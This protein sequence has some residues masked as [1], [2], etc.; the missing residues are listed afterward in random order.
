MPVGQK[1]R[2]RSSISVLV[3]AINTRKVV[4]RVRPQ[5]ANEHFFEHAELGERVRIAANQAGSA[6]PYQFAEKAVKA[7]SVRIPLISITDSGYAIALDPR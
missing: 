6:N 5:G 4:E 1:G 3:R 7:A 2:Q